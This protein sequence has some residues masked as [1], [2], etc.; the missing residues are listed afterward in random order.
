[1][2]T[3]ILGGIAAV[4]AAAEQGATIVT[5][6]SRSA[7]ALLEAYDRNLRDRGPRAWDTP[8]IIS[9]NGFVLRLWN[10]AVYGG[11]SGQL[12]LLNSSQERRLWQQIVAKDAD[13]LLN[14]AATAESARHAWG[15]AK[16]YAVPLGSPLYREHAESAAFAKWAGAFQDVCR[17]NEWLDRSSL[18]DLLIRLVKTGQ[19]R[20]SKRVVLVGFD[21]ITPQQE[22]LLESVSETGTRCEAIQVSRA[23]EASAWVVEARD[24]DDEIRAA[25]A[26]AR[27]RLESN[28]Q[29]RLA[30]VVPALDNVRTR[31]E[32]I[33]LAAFH[34]ERLAA[35]SGRQQRAF[36][37]SLGQPLAEYP[38]VA[39]ALQL[40]RL[41]TGSLTIGDAGELLLSPFLAGAETEMT[42]RAL[43]HAALRKQRVLE[44]T[45]ETLADASVNRCAVLH[46]GVRAMK[47]VIAN[48]P[49]G[50][51]APREWAELTAQ[52]LRAVG[53]PEGERGLNSE[54]Y[55]AAEAWTDLLS[56]FGSLNATDPVMDS[57]AFN[58]RLNECA[59]RTLFEPE[60]SGAPIQVMGLLEAAGSTFDAMWVMGL[61]DGAWPA[62]S[63]ATPLIPIELQLRCGVPH[64]SSQADLE[65]ARKVQQ[66]LLRSADEVVFSLPAKEGDTTLRPSPL[67][68]KFEYRPISEIIGEARASWGEPLLRSSELQVLH[69]ESAPEIPEGT[70]VKGGTKILQLQS[71]CPFRAYAELRLGA[72]QMD[73]PQPGLDNLQRGQ[74]VHKAMEFIWQRLKSRDG[75]LQCETLNDLVAD[76]V[77]QAIEA[78]EIRQD[79]AW[80]RRLAEIER[81]R[82]SNLV[83]E[84]L[85]VERGRAPFTVEEKEQRTKIDIGGLKLDVR[86][87]RIDRLEDGRQVLIDYK[88]GEVKTAS[89]EG[90]RPEEPQLPAYAATREG[91]IAAVA[92]AQVKA[93]SVGYCGYSPDPTAL[94][95]GDYSKTV[96]GK[97]GES[98]DKV[99]VRWKETVQRLA[100]KHREGHA[101]V[102][103]ANGPKTCEH[104]PLPALCRTAQDDISDEMEPR[105]EQ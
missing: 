51:L 24:S 10:E 14:P 23:S 26:W 44:L 93:G 29:A 36:E 94:A 78:S 72:V 69:D 37:L 42:A 74:I 48:V 22:A 11:C 16:Q 46:D 6:N 13:A 98:L 67:I 53:W 9:W 47:R 41:C 55:Q 27:A 33:F 71:A 105:D 58:A 60:K 62:R 15:L 86:I 7:R 80:E 52:M 68:R 95:A 59:T 89:W 101:E 63:A 82:V 92:F 65:F 73:S 103:P 84:L 56:E 81:E 31:I 5:A 54:E 96:A 28:P 104:C 20:S 21:Q 61:H 35:G 25:A 8:D 32:S 17:N 77:N 97:A 3:E 40:V 99:I 1:M 38:V 87:D 91:E 90:E 12:V 100:R 18:P 4:L 19:L 75:L 85:N 45:L 102:D 39:T 30:V 34:P 83:L 2:P 50:S 57:P 79:A 64:S 49:A 66:R 70:S 43:L 88:T 76:C